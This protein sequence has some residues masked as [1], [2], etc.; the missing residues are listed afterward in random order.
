MFIIFIF[1]DNH[2]YIISL[3][4]FIETKANDKLEIQNG[5]GDEGINLPINQN[6]R[7]KLTDFEDQG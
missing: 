2:I 5:T 4:S 1:L 6:L 3:K 7:Q